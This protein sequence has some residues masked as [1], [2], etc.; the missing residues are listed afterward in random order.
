MSADVNQHSFYFK[1]NLK[2]N[3]R[4]MDTFF[5]PAAGCVF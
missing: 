4:N 3:G 1:Q 5:D 2:N